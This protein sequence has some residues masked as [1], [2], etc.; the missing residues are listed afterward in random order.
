MMDYQKLYSG[1]SKAAWGFFFLYFNINFNNVSILPSFVGYLLFLSAINLL[2]EEEREFSLLH[3][4][5]V[6]M[7]LWTGVE[8]LASFVGLNLEGMWQFI[9]II[10]SLVNL[11]F[12]FQFLT[13]LASIAAKYQPEGYELDAKLL[14][15][16]TLQTVMLTAI[17]V[18]IRF[19]PWLSEA[20]TVISICMLLVYLIA[21]ICLMKALFDLR[22]CLPTNT[23]EA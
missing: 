19:Q 12:H 17:E 8:W 15:Y 4:L 23:I 21:G 18:I 9:D 16:R 20:W 1:I 7:A 14:R 22:K 13:N 6:I 5:G 11:Y 10:I 2:K 3:T